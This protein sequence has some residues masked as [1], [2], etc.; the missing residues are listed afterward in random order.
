MQQP[1]GVHRP[2]T[3]T[4]PHRAEG[5]AAEAEEREITMTTKTHLGQIDYRPE[6]IKEYGTPMRSLSHPAHTYRSYGG[7]IFQWSPDGKFQG[8]ICAAG[9]VETFKIVEIEQVQP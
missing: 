2:L 9:L 6:T 4:A 3:V 7:Y 5:R 1:A 8:W